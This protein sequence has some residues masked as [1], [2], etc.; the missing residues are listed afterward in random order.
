M[1]RPP[2]EQVIRDRLGLDP[3]AVGEPAVAAAV[4]ARLRATGVTSPDDYIPRLA[5]PAEVSALADEL[6]VPETWFF[7]GGRRLFDALAGHLARRS[8]RA[9]DRVVRALSVPCST[10]EEPFSLAVA[11]HETGL[12]SDRFR[13]DAVDVSAAHLARATAALYSASAFREP[14]PDPRPVHFRETGGRWELLPH[15]RRAVRFHQA[16]LTNPDFLAGEPPYDLVL[17]RNLFI[18]LT[19]DGRERATAHLERRLAAD[20]WLCLSP[21]EAVR[22]PP[23]RFVTVGPSEWC[24][25]RRADV[26]SAP[27]RPPAARP[28]AGAR[29]LPAVPAT[30]PEGRP[31]NR[32]T[33]ADPLPATLTAARELADAGR[34][35]EAE[36]ACEGALTAHPDSADGYALLGVILQA[37]G[38]TDAAAA[39]FRKGLYLDPEHPEALAHLLVHAEQRQDAAQAAALR[40]RLT[41]RA[42]RET[43]T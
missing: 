26:S 27:P 2:V 29:R 28:A 23:G 11:L 1:N 24:V 30:K 43:P 19:L 13:I 17:C 32:T 20:G 22:L 36:R 38:K 39:A 31:L 10:G 3:A 8:A 21:A 34:L 35:A 9:P 5:D 42:A 33:A 40:R 12:T 4:A 37:E 16:N 7:R 25:Y 41:R 6:V 15:L 14:G 18:Y